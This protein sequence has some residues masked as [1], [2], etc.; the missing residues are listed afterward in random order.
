MVA[1]QNNSVGDSFEEDKENE[2][3]NICFM[4]IDKLDEIN[5]NINYDDLHDALEDIYEDLEKL[6]LKNYCRPSILSSSH[7][8]SRIDFYI[9]YCLIVHL[10][11]FLDCFCALIDGSL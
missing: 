7:I 4:A 5:S 9:L 6:D 2:V 3:T 1:T 11:T 10:L 8:P